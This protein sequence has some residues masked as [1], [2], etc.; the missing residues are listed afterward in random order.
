MAKFFAPG[1]GGD[2][3]KLSVC[4][5]PKSTVISVLVLRKTK[6]ELL[7]CIFISYYLPC[8]ENVGFWDLT[9][10]TFPRRHLLN[11]LKPN[12]VTKVL[13]HTRNLCKAAGKIMAASARWKTQGRSPGVRGARSRVWKT[14]L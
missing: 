9:L 10:F 5:K 11:Y 6:L 7:F 13:F 8:N 1:R 4:Q 2:F 3:C 12:E 14:W